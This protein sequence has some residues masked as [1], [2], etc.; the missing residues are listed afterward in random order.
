[1]NFCP[2]C[3]TQLEA[4]AT[5]CPKCGAGIGRGTP[6]LTER[7]SKSLLVNKWN[8]AAGLFTAA[9]LVALMIYTGTFG[10][11]GKM[12]CTATLDQARAFGVISP[13]AKLASDSAN[14]TGERRRKSC[15]ASVGNDVYTMDVD[16]KVEDINHQR[17]RDYI[18]QPGCVALYRVARADGMTTYQVRDI[19]AD[20]TD[21][22]LV[23][24][25][26]LNSPN[27]PAVPQ[28]HGMPGGLPAPDDT[29]SATAGPA[30][31]A[32]AQSAPAAEAQ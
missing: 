27:P 21:D 6:S 10:P 1:M 25:G 7:L 26:A 11:S 14:S 4:A 9:G 32:D 28:S 24:R 3:G 2:E 18:K 31:G 16:V 20:D 22:A 23:A 17:C 12:L 15:T 29:V 30:A 8:W 19:P 13:S 5:A